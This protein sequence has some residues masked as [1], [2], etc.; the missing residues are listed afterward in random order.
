MSARP[1]RA[2]GE[3][4]AHHERAHESRRIASRPRRPDRASGDER[5]TPRLAAATSMRLVADAADGLDVLAAGD[6]GDDAAEAR[7]EIHLGRHH[8]RTQRFPR[9]R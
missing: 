2:L 7:V 4:H 8:I 9:R 5:A 6:L 1:G 3:G